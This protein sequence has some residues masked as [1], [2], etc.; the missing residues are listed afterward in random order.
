VREA[1][2]PEVNFKETL[3]R[4]RFKEEFEGEKIV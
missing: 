2:H 4:E 3:N 1:K